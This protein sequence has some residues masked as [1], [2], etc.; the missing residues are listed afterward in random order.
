M[1]RPAGCADADWH[2]TK[3]ER[4]ARAAAEARMQLARP[5]RRPKLL[6]GDKPAGRHWARIVKDMADTG[7][8]D[9]LDSDALGIYC[10]KLARRDDLQR[11]YLALR[12]QSGDEPDTVT[13]KTMLA[14]DS[15]LQSAEAQL[16]S[17]ASKL[18]LTPDSR[19][20][21]AKR[22]A[23]SNDADPNSDLFGD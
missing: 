11:R 20:R 17:Y 1:G 13:V 22:T 10:A 2:M 7:I 16:L 9:L 14:L 18:G 23:V 5:L 21:M 15:D 19:L 4:E 6:A 3:E 8:L 12:E